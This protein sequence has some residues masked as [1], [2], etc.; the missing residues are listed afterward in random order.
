MKKMIG[1]LIIVMFLLIGCKSSIKTS[2]EI[3]TEPEPLVIERPVDYQPHIPTDVSQVD[4]TGY[5]NY[6]TAQKRLIAVCKAGNQG[7]CSLVKTKYGL[8][9]KPQ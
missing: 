4:M 9:I 6:D 2:E 3:I 1:I 8:D 5:E 7:I